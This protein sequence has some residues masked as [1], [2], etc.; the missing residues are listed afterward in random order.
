MKTVDLCAS[1]KGWGFHDNAILV[2][3]HRRDYRTERTNCNRCNGTG[4][5][6]LFTQQKRE[7]FKLP[8]LEE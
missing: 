6:I 3:A 4:R 5:T 7:P 1:C 8:P 2:N